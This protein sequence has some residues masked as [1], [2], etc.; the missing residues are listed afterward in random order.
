MRSTNVSGCFL[1]A[2]AQRVQDWIPLHDPEP[3][4]PFDI[5][6]PV[7]Q[8]PADSGDAW[9]VK[10]WYVTLDAGA[11]QTPEIVVQPGQ[12]IFGNMTLI[13]DSTWFCGATVAGMSTNFSYSDP[14]LKTQ[15]WAYTT[16]EC[17]GCQDCSTFPTNQVRRS[18]GS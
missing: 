13:A 11:I 2:Y 5:V 9:S 7:L 17:Y 3:T 18:C 12:V 15:P 1:V 6:Q 8:T 14:R 16:L 10:S 4:I